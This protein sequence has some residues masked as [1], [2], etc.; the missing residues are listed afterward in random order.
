MIDSF[1]KVLKNGVDYEAS[2]TGDD[3]VPRNVDEY[4]FFV[5]GLGDY[6]MESIEG[7]GTFRIYPQPTTIKKVK[8]A[9]KSMTVTW[10]KKTAQVG[11]Y[12]I[13]YALNSTFTKGRKTVTVKKNSISSIKIK[14]LKSKKKY[15]VRIRTFKYAPSLEENLYSTWSKAKKIKVK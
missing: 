10:T 8:A 11:G 14:K 2:V 4:C 15:Y 3:D 5:D 13:Q 6:G 7:V 12:Q 1:G 9:K